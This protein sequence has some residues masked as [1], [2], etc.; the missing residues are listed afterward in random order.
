VEW[1]QSKPAGWRTGLVAEERGGLTGA[2]DSTA[3]QTKQWGAMA[4]EQRSNR[5]RPLGG[6]RAAVS[7]GG[8]RG[9]KG[10]L[11]APP[12]A[13]DRVVEDSIPVRGLKLHHRS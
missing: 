5:G 1:P 4:V 10:G 3:A 8:G 11:E 9:G 12:R 7:S 13:L 2:G 6:H